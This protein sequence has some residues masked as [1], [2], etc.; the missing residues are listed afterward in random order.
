VEKWGNGFPP[1]CEHCGGPERSGSPITFYE[2]D[3]ELYR[4]HEGCRQEWLAGPD[5]NG[6][7]FNLDDRP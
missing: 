6:W 2:K 7:T 1:V 4:L 5:P 3:G